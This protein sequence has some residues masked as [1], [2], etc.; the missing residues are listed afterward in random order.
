MRRLLE[1]RRLFQ[2]WYPKERRLFEAWYLLE[3]KRYA[4]NI[5][6]YLSVYL[7]ICLSVY[8]LSVSLS[9]CLSHSLNIIDCTDALEYVEYFF[10]IMHAF[11]LI[12]NL[13]IFSYKFLRWIISKI[14]VLQKFFVLLWYFVCGNYKVKYIVFNSCF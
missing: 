9:F 14:E 7:S 3:E 8:L 2:C 12:L 6:I 5:Y 13:V 11:C 10:I 4:N 1:G